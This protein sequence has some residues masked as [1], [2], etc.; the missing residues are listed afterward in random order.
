M[1]VDPGNGKAR[2]YDAE[3]D[4]LQT[5]DISATHPDIAR[6]LR[7]RAEEQ[8]QMVNYL[9]EANRVWPDQPTP[10]AERH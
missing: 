6:G 3:T 7:S 10:T 1:V 2:L 8:R 9:L 5:K 4:P